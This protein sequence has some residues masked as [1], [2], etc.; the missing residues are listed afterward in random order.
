MEKNL[1]I[2]QEQRRKQK[3]S[4]TMLFFDDIEGNFVAGS[5]IREEEEQYMR[6]EQLR[7]DLDSLRR[8]KMEAE[9]LLLEKDSRIIELSFDVEAANASVVRH[10]RRTQ[11][12]ENICRDMS[13]SEKIG[14]NAAKTAW[15]GDGSDARGTGARLKR[16]RDLE[17]VVESMKVV[18]DKLK[19]ENDRLRKNTTGVPEHTKAKTDSMKKRIQELEEEINELRSKSSKQDDSSQK[20]VQKTQQ[21][22]SLRKAVKLK[23]DEVSELNARIQSSDSEKENIKKLLREAQN[24]VQQLEIQISSRLSARD[25]GSNISAAATEIAELK[26]KAS[27]SNTEIENLNSKIIELRKELNNAK[28][29]NRSTPYQGETN[30]E[31]RRL[32]EENAKLKKELSAFDLEFFEEIENLK[33]AHAEAVR[34]LKMYERQDGRNQR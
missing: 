18:I 3:A 24:K 21:I 29:N 1:R 20:M 34:K 8:Q 15:G 14:S 16:E 6:E 32:S 7:D 25:A 26:R 19:L 22:A 9:A 30:A 31:I 10:R 33:F 28:A 27:M 12:L 2:A 4:G 23:E 17:G 13:I 11:E 5:V